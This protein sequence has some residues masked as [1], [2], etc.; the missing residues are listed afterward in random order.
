MP[1]PDTVPVADLKSDGPWLVFD[2]A[3]V[4]HYGYYQP[5][6][7]LWGMNAT[8]ASGAGL[9]DTDMLVSDFKQNPYDKKLFVYV[10]QETLESSPVLKML[11]VPEGT[12]TTIT[13]I[14]TED[15][16]HAEIDEE[17]E[18]P[19]S[20][21]F[22]SYSYNNPAWS[23]DGTKVAFIG[24]LDDQ[25]LDVYVCDFITN[26]VRR[27]ADLV[28]YETLVGASSDWTPA[29]P[30]D[31]QWSPDGQ[32]VLFK[33]FPG[34]M[35]PGNPDPTQGSL[36][37]AHLDGQ[38]QVQAVECDPAFGAPEYFGWWGPG[39]VIVAAQCRGE[40]CP[41]LTVDLET[42]LLAKIDQVY[43]GWGQV[44]YSY[45]H[46]AWLI[47]NADVSGDRSSAQRG[48]IIR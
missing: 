35:M 33:D 42:G 18:T 23:P 20:L 45:E 21:L 47:I 7:Q 27:I 43:R 14:V 30:Y 26:E 8:D 10:V 34:T 9:F 37:A 29:Y 4:E 36:W 1:I 12:T 15:A 17:Y 22:A 6:K 13:P 28:H 31:L 44:A 48:W 2:S 38:H 19:S 11:R 40:G 5:R 24:M 16:F 46:N 3:P 41:I 25:S 32:Y 39:H